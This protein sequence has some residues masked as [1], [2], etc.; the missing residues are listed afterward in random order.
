MNYLYI[1][2]LFLGLS[3]L[4]YLYILYARKKAILDVPNERSSHTN[5]TIRGAGIIFLAAVIFGFIL[6][7]MDHWQLGLAMII[8]GITGYLD[9][10]RTLGTSIRMVLY[11]LCAGLITFEIIYAFSIVT[12]WFWIPIMFI[13]ILGAVNTFN[14]MDGINGITVLYVLVTVVSLYAFPINSIHAI[15]DYADPM[16]IALIVFAFVN[17]RKN[18]VCFM[19]DVGSIILGLLVS[20]LVFGFAFKMGRI[21]PLLLFSVYGVDSLGTIIIRL[22]N[23]E[24]ITHAHRS[25]AYQLLSNE[26]GYGH[27]PVALIYACVQLIVNIGL[28]MHLYEMWL[29]A[30]VFIGGTLIIL[31]T[32]YLLVKY[33]FNKEALLLWNK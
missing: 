6:S 18:A 26:A 30:P 10:T 28:Y 25:H 17:L 4:L 31:G 16:V 24:N 33:R 3:L 5:E 8:G 7:G 13:F 19:G 29:P 23:K 12:H 14:F 2:A 20:F 21:A 22:L 32:L 1:I 9:D 11:A 15:L 27:I